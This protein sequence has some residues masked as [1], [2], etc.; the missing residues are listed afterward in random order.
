MMP[1]SDGIWISETHLGGAEFP[2]V[3][4]QEVNT[5]ANDHNEN[6]PLDSLP[7][8][9]FCLHS[10]ILLLHLQY[11]RDGAAKLYHLV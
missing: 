10:S 3:Y 1:E 8:R 2:S 9:L 4:P 6:D 5:V 7:H 11:R